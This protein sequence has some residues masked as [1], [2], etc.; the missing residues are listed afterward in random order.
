M[1]FE[2]IGHRARGAKLP[3]V[4][5]MLAHG[6]GFALV[7]LGVSAVGAHVR[8]KALNGGP[9]AGDSCSVASRFGGF[10]VGSQTIELSV[11]LLGVTLVALD[12]LFDRFLLVLSDRLPV[13]LLGLGRL[14]VLRMGRL[15]KRCGSRHAHHKHHDRDFTDE[16]LHVVTLD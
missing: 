15:I 5:V 14:H 11:V 7:L 2:P 12:V 16:S 8:F 13:W 3:V 10:E 1:E 6:F 9:V 4:L